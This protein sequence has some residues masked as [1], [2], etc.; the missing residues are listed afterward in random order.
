MRN[1]LQQIPPTGVGFG[2]GD[3]VDRALGIGPIESFGRMGLIDQDDQSIALRDNISAPQITR[4]AV[5]HH[6]NPVIAAFGPVERF[7]EC[8]GK[9]GVINDV[10]GFLSG[11]RDHGD[12]TV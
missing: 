1:R 3:Q 9:F 4:A 5:G 8:L 6:Q 12:A 10:N 2:H 7:A 11:R